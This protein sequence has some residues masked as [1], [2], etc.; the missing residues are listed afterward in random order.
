MEPPAAPTSA[1]SAPRTL[2]SA[3][4]HRKHQRKL[5]RLI[6]QQQQSGETIIPYT[7]FSRIV[8]ELVAEAG[9]Y[10]VRSE[11]VRAL[12]E[13]A[14]DRMTDMFFDANKLATYSGRETV[15]AADLKF[16]TPTD[17]WS[18]CHEHDED[19]AMSD[20]FVLPP[21]EPDPQ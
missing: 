7:S 20:S 2:S 11:A 13:A 4:A 18:A 3:A 19:A 10:C 21:P 16:V 17:E 1:P 9:D 5:Q 12:Q 6:R 14:E 15:N 8:H